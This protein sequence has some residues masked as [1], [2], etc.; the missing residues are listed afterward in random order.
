MKRVALLVTILLAGCASPGGLQSDMTAAQIRAT[1]GTIVC[2]HFRAA[3]YGEADYI[4]LNQDDT[5]KGATSTNDVTIACGEAV[6]QIKA[7][8]G[9]PVP[10]GATTITTTT[11]TPAK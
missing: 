6:I 4:A 10:A 2:G 8:A 5:R 9:V 11:V 3:L 1:A 7:S